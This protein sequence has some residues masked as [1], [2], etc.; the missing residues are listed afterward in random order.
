MKDNTAGE[1]DIMKGYY[2]RRERREQVLSYLSDGKMRATSEIAKALKMRNT[3]KF[4]TML[5]DLWLD[6]HILAYKESNMY[7]WQK[8]T[9]EQLVLFDQVDRQPN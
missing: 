3:T 1:G 6:G 7:R 9:L 4:R 5:I 2:S 8:P